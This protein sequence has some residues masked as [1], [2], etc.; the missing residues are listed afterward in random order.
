[1]RS[2]R[3]TIFGVVIAGVV[4]L[5]A[6]GA[7]QRTSLAFTLGV[8]PVAPVV[9]LHGGQE[10]CQRPIDVPSGGGFDRVSL[11]LG[12]YHRAGPPGG[13]TVRDLGGRTLASGRIAGGYPDVAVQ[14]SHVIRLDRSVAA[15]GR[16]AVCVR[17]NG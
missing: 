8:V 16:I 3:F 5:V 7:A 17:D 15:P 14:P 13:V 2:A 1:M 10:V 9:G 11:Q 12:T 6:V 4:C